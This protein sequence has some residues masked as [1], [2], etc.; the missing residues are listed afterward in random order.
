MKHSLL[1]VLSL[2]S[3]AA[4]SQ[5]YASAQLG[6]AHADFPLGAPFDDNVSQIVV[7]VGL[8]L[9]IGERR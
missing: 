6:W 5:T 9:G 7:C 4:L 1:I 3:S 8:G 2:I